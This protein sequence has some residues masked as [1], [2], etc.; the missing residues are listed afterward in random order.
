[1]FLGWIILGGCVGWIL[2][3]SNSIDLLVD[4]GAMVVSFLSGPSDRELDSA[5]MPGTNAGHFSQSLVSLTRQ[6]LTMPT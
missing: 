5:G 6:F 1:M 2:P 3:V 4:F